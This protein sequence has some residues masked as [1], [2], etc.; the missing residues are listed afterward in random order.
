MITWQEYA[1]AEPD[2]LETPAMLLFQ[3]RM[4]HNIRQ[5]CEMVG[6]AQNLIPHVKTHRFSAP[7]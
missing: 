5:V 3:D 2:A 6:G 4:E 1:V 7:P